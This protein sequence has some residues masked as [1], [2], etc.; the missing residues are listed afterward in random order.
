MSTST[1]W[2]CLSFALSGLIWCAPG[3]VSAQEFNDD[4]G[5]FWSS[6]TSYRDCQERQTWMRDVINIA[7]Q[8]YMQYLKDTPGLQFTFIPEC[9]Y[10]GPKSCQRE[11]SRACKS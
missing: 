3:A 11:E 4:A 10:L 6:P 9:G 1:R 8:D 5:L 2:W 7:Q